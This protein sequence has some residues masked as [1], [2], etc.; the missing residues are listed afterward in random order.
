[1]PKNASLAVC[2]SGVAVGGW[3]RC[4]KSATSATSHGFAEE[5]EFGG[6]AA[7][8][9]APLE[10]AKRIRR[11]QVVFMMLGYCVRTRMFRGKPVLPMRDLFP[12]SAYPIS[13]VA[14][15]K[16]VL[17]PFMEYIY[18]TAT[19]GLP[20]TDCFVGS[21]KHGD[22]HWLS[23]QAARLSPGTILVATLWVDL[24]PTKRA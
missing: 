5:W 9:E 23:C 22:V 18:Q 20:E 4:S 24:R 13:D 2:S 3:N 16:D 1:M 6:S 17:G 7:V 8:C 12:G 15:T 10:V 11:P 14:W 19:V 21:N